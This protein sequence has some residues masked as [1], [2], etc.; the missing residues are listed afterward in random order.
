MEYSSKPEYGVTIFNS[1]ENTSLQC[2]PC[3]FTEEAADRSFVAVNTEDM[4][5]HV[6]AHIS[7]GHKVPLNLKDQLTRDDA[8][9]YPLS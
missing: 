9:N 1:D 5:K 8:T 6:N 4:L 2:N 7:S 3:D